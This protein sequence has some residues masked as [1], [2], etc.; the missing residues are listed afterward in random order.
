MSTLNFVFPPPPPPPPVAAQQ[1]S[2][3]PPQPDKQGQR[4]SGFDNPRNRGGYGQ[5]RGRGTWSSRGSVGGRGRGARALNGYPG[6]SGSHGSGR[7]GY[8][9]QGQYLPAG[10]DPLSSHSLQGSPGSHGGIANGSIMSAGYTERDN[11]YQNPTWLYSSSTTPTRP[12]PQATKQ[13]FHH[14]AQPRT[15]AP[16]C[17]PAYG[18]PLP[19][20]TSGAA[21]KAPEPLKKKRKYNQLGLTPKTEDHESSEEDIDEEAKL[22]A[23]IGS[24]TGLAGNQYVWPML[25]YRY[26]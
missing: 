14:S 12:T 26:S 18:T 11:G 4:P 23:A 6:S 10:T 8:V 25:C 15:T 16:P 22:A 7:G 21:D 17:V 9:G 24:A 2:F 5:G 19:S 20:I 3:L 13:N 1:G